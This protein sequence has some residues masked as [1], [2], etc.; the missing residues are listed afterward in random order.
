M[1]FAAAATIGSAVIGAVGS[2]K[3]SGGTQT[4]TTSNEPWAE[5]QPWLKNNIQA[6]QNLQQ[7]Y[8]DNPF[9]QQ[10]KE[11]Y[12]NLFG[13]LDSFRVQMAPELFNFANG[14]MNNQYQ[15]QQYSRPGMAGY[16][17]VT[18]NQ[19]P[20]AWMTRPAFSIRQSNY[21]LPQFV[22]PQGLLSTPA[23]TATTEPAPA[24]LTQEE[25]DARIRAAIAGQYDKYSPYYN[26]GAG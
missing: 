9:N 2:K 10:Q 15:R 3:S 13:D 21:S 1:S 23:P 18:Q 26:G 12:T 4:Q 14:M 25:I 11:A 17:P 20:N 16:S 22:A 7:Y 6:G 8:Q 19:L 24:A 5:A